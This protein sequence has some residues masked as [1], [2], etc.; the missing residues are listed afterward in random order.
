MH[1]AQILSQADLRETDVLTQRSLTPIPRYK[2]IPSLGGPAGG[3][4]SRVSAHHSSTQ[5]PRHF[6]LKENGC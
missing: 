3:N 1:A 6:Y 4:L 2:C 5:S